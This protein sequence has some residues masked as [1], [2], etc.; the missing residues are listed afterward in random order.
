MLCLGGG[1]IA[2]WVIFVLVIWYISIFLV[3][4]LLY[5][6]SSEVS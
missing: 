4:V 6:R 1:S 3:M 5:S 2:E